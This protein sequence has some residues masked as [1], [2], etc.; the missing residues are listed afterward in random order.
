MKRDTLMSEEKQ[1]ELVSAVKQ[2]ADLVSDGSDPTD[3]VVKVARLRGFNENQVDL[4]TQAFNTGATLSHF[5]TATDRAETF[6][7]A[8]GERA[9]EALFPK[10]AE[11]KA[12]ADREVSKIL[13]QPIPDL[14]R[15]VMDSMEKAAA[16]KP[17]EP[18]GS[19]VGLEDETLI[20]GGRESEKKLAAYTAWRLKQDMPAGGGFMSLNLVSA[21]RDIEYQRYLS[22]SLSEK[23]ASYKDPT[24]LEVPHEIYLDHALKAVEHWKTA[25]ARLASESSEYLKIAE[26]TISN[27]AGIFTAAGRPDWH[28]F[29]ADA[30]A[31]HGS[32]IKPYLDVVYARGSLGSLKCARASEPSPGFINEAREELTMLEVI[33]VAADI[34]VELKA[35]ENEAIQ[36]YTTDRQAIL[37]GAPK[38]AGVSLN[39]GNPMGLALGLAQHFDAQIPEAKP[40]TAN[41]DPGV[42][43]ES[44][45]S[46]AKLQAAV[47][48]LMEND[49]VIAKHSKTDPGNVLSIIEELSKLHPNITT[50]PAVMQSGVRKAL[51]L[52]SMEPFEMKQLQSIGNPKTEPP[53]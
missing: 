2:A 51:E 9:R 50:M 13:R 31:L 42:G 27:L 29:E 38:L 28:Q 11:A 26:D 4:M 41:L 23:G 37:A 33:K 17:A 20:T 19:A 34:L 46:K 53:K 43:I 25:A 16:A 21:D 49:P 35:R 10:D 15:G 39:V 32:D 22:E 30:L 24:A 18:A 8:N 52:G 3:A 47:K 6:P 5:K 44:E 45:L 36:N 40:S 12:A 14:R 7:I 48:D 1:R